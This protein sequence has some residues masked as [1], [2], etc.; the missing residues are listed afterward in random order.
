LENAK[1]MAEGW[2]AKARDND[3]YRLAFDLEGTWS[4]K[5]NLIWDQIFRTNIFSKEIKSKEFAYYL[6]KQNKYG[7]PLDSRNT[8]TKADWLVWVASMTDSKQA[9]QDMIS[10]LWDFTNETLN[11]VPFTDWYDTVTGAQIA[12]QHRSVIGGI[13]IKIL[14]DREI[15]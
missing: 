5:Y 9:F 12:F 1:K 10:P 8:Y 4:L 15:F 7:I 13:F 11:R 2:E 6:S 3:H 14:K